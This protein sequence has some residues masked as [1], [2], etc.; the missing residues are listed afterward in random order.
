[1]P[2]LRKP[3][4]IRGKTTFSLEI[5]RL[6]GVAEWPIAP[7]LKTG[8]AQA[9]EGSNPSPSADWHPQGI[10]RGFSSTAIRDLGANFLAPYRRHLRFLW[11]PISAYL[12]PLFHFSLNRQPAKLTFKER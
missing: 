1:M 5:P 4:K 7:V 10:R 12:N 11:A 3:R 9:I 2:R 6:G 8:M